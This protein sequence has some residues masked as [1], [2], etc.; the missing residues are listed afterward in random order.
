ME[1]RTSSASSS[2]ETESF[3]AFSHPPS[4]RSSSGCSSI[5]D[6]P[7]NPNPIPIPAVYTPQPPQDPDRLSSVYDSVRSFFA[8]PPLTMLDRIMTSLTAVVEMCVLIP[9]LLCLLVYWK[10]LALVTKGGKYILCWL[11]RGREGRDWLGSR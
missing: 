4:H 11:G 5:S 6:H 9:I 10:I 3:S 2:S 7:I 8:L 1:R